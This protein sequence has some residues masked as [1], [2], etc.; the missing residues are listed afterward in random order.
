[1]PLIA[2]IGSAAIR[3]AFVAVLLAASI[4]VAQAN[5]FLKI[6][7]EAGEAGT[8]TVRSGV[9]VLDRAAA[10]IKALPPTA[11]GATLAAHATPEGH[12]KF[13]NRNGDVFTAGT[14]DEFKRVVPTLLPEKASDTKLTIYLTED[15]VFGE[16]A[17]LKA[18]PGEATLHVIVGRDSFPLVRRVGSAG[19][20]FFAQVRPNLIVELTDQKLFNEAI[21]QLERPLNR[22][23][24]RTLSLKPG[25]RQT[26][27]SAP[28]M[29]AG[30]KNALVDSID[31]AN[32]DDAVRS[33]RGQTVLV[34]GRVEGN[35]LFFR[36]ES[37]PEQSLKVL[38]VISAAENA[39]VNLVILHSQAPRQ[40][41]GRNWL[42]QRI[43]VDG[44]DAAVKRATLG[45]FLDGLAASRGQF[46]VTAA[47]EGSGRVIVRAMPASSAAQPITGVMGEWLSVATSEITG[48]VIVDAVDVYA[49]DEARQ[50][51]LDRRIIPWIPWSYQAAYLGGLLAGLIGWTVTRAWWRHIWPAEQREEYRGVAGYRAAQTVRF[52]AYFVIF[53]PIVGVPALIF[54]L[55]RYAWRILM[56]PLRFFRKHTQGV[57]PKAG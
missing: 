5:W 1:M 45:D 35:L 44:L 7:R 14:P 3:S 54:L 31:P 21:A 55:L 47:R 57:E 15:T 43:S 13:V 32:L 37:G 9:A 16:R 20:K 10:H 27:S 19:D 11:K 38:D 28:R 22:S 23:S 29:E 17:I 39:D 33:V 49:R 24:I 6:A 42:W 48:N 8:K 4:P 12:W 36:P 50:R 34:T 56:L 40:P 46:T 53:L 18:L 26:L 52:L 51:E 2:A 25:G 41:G 30:T